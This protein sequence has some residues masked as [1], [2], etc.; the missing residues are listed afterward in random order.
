MTTFN[1]DAAV[2]EKFNEAFAQQ[3]AEC[4]RVRLSECAGIPVPPV[5]YNLAGTGDYGTGTYNLKGAE[6]ALRS[7]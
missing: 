5:S 3:Y 1:I 4:Q 2:A 7:F 6:Y